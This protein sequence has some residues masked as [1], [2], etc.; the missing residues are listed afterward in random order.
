M[1]LAPTSNRR[2]S[3]SKSALSRGLQIRRTRHDRREADRRPGD[4]GSWN[5][6]GTPND[7]SCAKLK[8]NILRSVVLLATITLTSCV[9]NP[10]A[11]LKTKAI[12][13]LFRAEGIVAT[14]VAASAN[15]G[16]TFVYND[17][18]S[19]QRFSPASTFKIPNTLI[20]LDAL[21]VASK[22]SIFEWDGIDKGMQQWNQ[23]QTLESAFR[24]SCVWCYQEIARKVG[25]KRYKSA[26]TM[27]SYGNQSIG[28]EVDSFWLTGDLQISAREQI[29]FLRKLSQYAVPFR[30]EHVE[31]LR[32]I[33][34]VEQTDSYAIY[35]KTGWAATT[36]QVAW[37]VGF[38]TKGYETWLFAMNMRVDRPEQAELR[39]ELTIRSLRLL[40]II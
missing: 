11:H 16:V 15:G 24:V 26:L 4:I 5:P 14:L 3:R 33:M 12:D 9:D 17:S 6:C 22:D 36:P 28:S 1:G 21:V 30:R 32:D 13:D 34:L 35:A 37:Y 25:K 27:L 18:R 39:K 19:A 29:E 38:V 31:T 8:D 40:D 10:A 7:I 20:A 2:V 23:D